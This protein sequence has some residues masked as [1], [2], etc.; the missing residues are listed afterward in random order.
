MKISSTLY[1]IGRGP[2]S[3]SLSANLAM[4]ALEQR[5]WRESARAMPGLLGVFYHYCFHHQGALAQRPLVLR[6]PGIA[7]GQ[8]IFA[9]AW[10][11][12]RQE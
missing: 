4:A 12:Q 5:E 10:A 8:G 9:R 6:I 11:E 1:F 2:G 7:T 3:D